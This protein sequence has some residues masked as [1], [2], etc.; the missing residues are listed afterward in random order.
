MSHYEN[1]HLEERQLPFIYKAREVRPSSRLFGSSNWHENIEILY[2]IRGEGAVSN[3]AQVH[4]VVEGDIVVI[5]SNHLHTLAAGEAPMFHRYL[6]VDRSFCLSNGFDTNLIS[7]EAMVSTPRVRALMDRL[8]EEY[9]RDVSDPYRT[10]G[11]RLTVLEL[12][13][14]LCMH[15]SSPLREDFHASRILT[16]IKQAIDYIR[17]SYDKDFSLEDVAEFVGINKYYLSR[18]FHKYTGYSFVAYVNRT[19]CLMA[20]KLLSEERLSISEVGRRCGFENRSYF[21]KSFKSYVG[22]LPG[23]YRAS[24]NL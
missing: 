7:F 5:N 4:P 1:H 18:E 10:L 9:Q 20:Q 19:R 12:M 23:E 13:R 15:H 11:I 22:M 14:E 17:A 21:A 2:I 3:N 24:S 6:I 8:E 16:C